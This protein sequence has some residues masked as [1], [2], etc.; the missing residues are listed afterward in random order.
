VDSSQG[1]ILQEVKKNLQV[2]LVT[3][4]VEFYGPL[5]ARDLLRPIL[6]QVLKDLTFNKQRVSV[7]PS[8]PRP[9]ISIYRD[10]LITNTVTIRKPDCLGFEWFIQLEPGFRITDKSGFQMVYFRW[11]RASFYQ[12]IRKPDIFVRFSKGLLAS[13]FLSI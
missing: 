9:A 5:L 10:H 1:T 12:T 6:E 3:Y 13:T 2:I 11:N 7:L 8:N 4:K